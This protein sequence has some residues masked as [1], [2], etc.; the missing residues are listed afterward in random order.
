MQILRKAC[1]GLLA[2]FLALIAFGKACVDA[3][4]DGLE[5][6]LY[7]LVAD[8]GVSA[9]DREEMD[10]EIIAAV[11]IAEVLVREHCDQIVSVPMSS[12]VESLNAGIATGV[13]LYEVAHRR[14]KA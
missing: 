11:Q 12:A 14:R 1:L 2:Q 7:H 5:L 13:T 10:L 3:G 4:A 8:P 9:T 6:N